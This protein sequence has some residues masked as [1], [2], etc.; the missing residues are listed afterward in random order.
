MESQ[1][2]LKDSLE[3]PAT[4]TSGLPKVQKV[5]GNMDKRTPQSSKS[6]RQ[7]GQAD[8]SK[9]KKLPAT[10]MDTMRSTPHG[11]I[12][13]RSSSGSLRQSP[14]V[15]VAGNTLTFHVCCQVWGSAP[16]SIAALSGSAALSAPAP[17]SPAWL[18]MPSP[19]RSQSLN[20]EC[21][22]SEKSVSLSEIL[23]P[24]VQKSLSLNVQKISTFGVNVWVF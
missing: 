12:Q 16:A 20:I 3:L 7:H 15:Y 10:L 2:V 17:D 4:W 24:N 21:K 11:S 5:A 23:S 8:S 6:C 13:W 22:S 19:S 14:L 18:W 9:F 1:S